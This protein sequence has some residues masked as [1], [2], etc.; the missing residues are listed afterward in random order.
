MFLRD[1]TI[2]FV[3]LTIIILPFTGDNE[4]GWLPDDTLGIMPLNSHLWK[5]KGD[6]SSCF[7]RS[8]LI[9]TNNSLVFERDNLFLVI[10]QIVTGFRRF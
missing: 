9:F 10:S 7:K 4:S 1:Q 8:H 5:G 6:P 3:D 2:S